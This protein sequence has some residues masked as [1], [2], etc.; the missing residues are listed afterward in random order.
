M[1]VV[2]YYELA[3]QRTRTTQQGN[4]FALSKILHKR[5]T[6]PRDIYVCVKGEIESVR[7]HCCA[8]YA[9]VLVVCIFVYFVVLIDNT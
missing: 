6:C 9:C 5:L 8:K 2:S 1:N 4:K 3:L 7:G